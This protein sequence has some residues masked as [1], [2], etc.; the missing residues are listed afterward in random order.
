MRGDGVGQRLVGLRMWLWSGVAGSLC[1][2]S[3]GK[4]PLPGQHQ[5]EQGQE[6]E[7]LVEHKKGSWVRVDSQD[8]A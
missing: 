3:N 8:F 7:G 1:D 5:G 6:C 4:C 2:A